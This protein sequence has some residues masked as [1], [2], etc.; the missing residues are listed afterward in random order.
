MTKFCLSC[1]VKFVSFA[2]IIVIRFINIYKLILDLLS[3]INLILKMVNLF[4]VHAEKPSKF[5]TQ[6]KDKEIIPEGK[7]ITV[8]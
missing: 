1:D 7:N 3:L 2:Q 5:A 8:R 4:G 6:E